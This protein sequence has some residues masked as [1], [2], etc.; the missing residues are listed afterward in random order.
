MSGC[1]QEQ[2]INTNHV[3]ST[4]FFSIHKFR[5]IGCLVIFHELI[6]QDFWCGVLWG[7]VVWIEQYQAWQA[8]D[9]DV[10]VNVSICVARSPEK[11]FLWSSP[12]AWWNYFL[13]SQ[14]PGPRPLLSWPCLAN[15]SAAVELLQVVMEM[16]LRWDWDGISDGNRMGLA[17]IRMK[18]GWI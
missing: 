18:L 1:S 3:T 16:E 15:S 7:L 5:A 17:T 11:L 12:P 2:L 13:W 10:I 4:M 8:V 6:W 9:A 14:P